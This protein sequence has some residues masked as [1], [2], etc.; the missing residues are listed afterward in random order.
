MAHTQSVRAGVSLGRLHGGEL[1]MDRSDL[2]ALFERA[3]DGV[4]IVAADQRIIFWNSAA[5]R[6]LGYEPKEA[7]GRYCFDVLAGGDYQGHPFCR[8]HCPTIQA[9]IRGKSV[10][11]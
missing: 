7:L 6:I 11:N 4:H 9:A 1:A 8:R 5:S 10:P 3:A 2:F